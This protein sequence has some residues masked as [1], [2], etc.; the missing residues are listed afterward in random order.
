[1]SMHVSKFQTDA[2]LNLK[3]VILFNYGLFSVELP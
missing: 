3:L 1:M 2:A